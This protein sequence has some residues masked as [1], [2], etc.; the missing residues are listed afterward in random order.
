M[1]KGDEQQEQ[2]VHVGEPLHP[3]ADAEELFRAV[4]AQT[5]SCVA[6]RISPR[7]DEH[8]ALR[9]ARLF[10]E[11]IEKRTLWAALRSSRHPP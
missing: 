6:T 5:C 11:R 3:Q 7:L 1:P 4:D 8:P 2:G 10:A 9:K